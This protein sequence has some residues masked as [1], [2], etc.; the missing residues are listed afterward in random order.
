LINIRLYR[1]ECK[2]RLQEKIDNS[3]PGTKLSVTEWDFGSTEHWS[4]G[5]AVADVLGVYGKYG[6]YAATYWGTLDAYGQAGFKIY[7]NYDGNGSSYGDQAISAESSDIETATIYAATNSEDPDALHIIAINKSA[8]AQTA[9]FT[10]NNFSSFSLVDIYSFN[11]NSSSIFQEANP[12]MIDANMFSYELSPHSVNHIKLSGQSTRIASP[13]KDNAFEI[14][15]LGNIQIHTARAGVFK[16]ELLN[17]LG[18]TLRSQLFQ[19]DASQSI[20]LGNWDLE[21]PAILRLYGPALQ[22]DITYHLN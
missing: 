13:T 19:S 21:G 8:S 6:V 4:G 12:P 2:S 11:E 15:A 3:Y 16:A 20:N 10:I 17:P 7:S 9:H 22:N 1:I 5:L 18:R 14:D